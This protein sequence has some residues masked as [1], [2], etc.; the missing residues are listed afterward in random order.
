M[1]FLYV[2]VA[3]IACGSV[4]PLAA[5]HA[6]DETRSP[7]LQDLEKLE[8]KYQPV[9]EHLQD[10]R[11]RGIVTLKSAAVYLSNAGKKEACEEVVEAVGE[12]FSVRESEL[13]DKGILKPYDE[14][15]RLKRLNEA[16][17]NIGNQGTIRVGDL[18][19]AEVRN[20][21]DEDLGDV[22]DVIINPSDGTAS[23]LL[24]STG[25]FL[26]I[27]E[28]FVAV[29]ID[30]IGVTEARDFVVLNISEDDFEKAPKV[31]PKQ[32]RNAGDD[33]WRKEADQYFDSH[34]RGEVTP[35]KGT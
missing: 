15:A 28:D 3:A 17:A 16:A 22:E 11:R 27:G 26:G 33:P 1:R 7:C 5:A 6:A 4:L 25:G 23:H 32:L 13:V 9:R 21:K 12:I 10:T 30:R 20:L 29:P 19:G 18:I 31:A 2:T 35:G 34:A 24:V 14:R 8:S